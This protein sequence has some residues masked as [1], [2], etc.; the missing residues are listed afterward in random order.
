MPYRNF[1]DKMRRQTERRV[2]RR[3]KRAYAHPRCAIC[4]NPMAYGRTGLNL[5]AVTCS[6]RCAITRSNW[7]RA[8]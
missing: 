8:A 5:R 3:Q 2:A 7:M 4:D 1:S 6:R